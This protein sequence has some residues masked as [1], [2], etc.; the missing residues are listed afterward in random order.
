MSFD[1][2]DG[3]HQLSKRDLQWYDKLS[4]EDKKA[5]SPFVIARW[6]TGTSDP[7]QIIRLNTFVNPYCFSLGQDK[8]LLFKLI[9]AAATGKTTRYQWLKSPGSKKAMKLSVTALSQYYDVST[10]EAALY[11]KTV[12]KED[13]IEIA[14]QLGW[15][16]DE[17]TKL[18]K[19]VS[20]EQGSSEKPSGVKKKPR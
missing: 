14:E 11:L 9:A 1:L 12:N 15:E 2:F 3:L 19:E 13:I 10:R 18:K 17:L 20:D 16:K 8:A 5:A 4:E 7:A 6:M